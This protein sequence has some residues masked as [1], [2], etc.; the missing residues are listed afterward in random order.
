MEPA[1]REA[2][3][4]ANR[5]RGNNAGYRRGELFDDL[6]D[7]AVTQS[8]G[9]NSGLN[10]QNNLRQAVGGAIRRTKGESRASK[11][12]YND[13]EIAAMEQFAR[14]PFGDAALRYVDR[15]AGGGGGLGAMVAG[16]IGGGYIGQQV[17][18]S[19][20]GG[21]ALGA[22]VPAAGLALRLIG[23]RRAN[24]NMQELSEMVRRRTPL[25]QERAAN[26]PMVQPGKSGS[27]MLRDAI[28]TGLVKNVFGTQE[29]AEDDPL[30]ITVTPRR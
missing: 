12:H 28:T 18:D 13:D 25:Y 1:A 9:A 29:D 23:N 17:K 16:G 26:A 21:F 20:V 30:R 27:Q 11:A 6:W 19:P 2:T 24:A 3:A 10:L 22:G 14:V 5:A 15:L 4:L 8:G 7:N